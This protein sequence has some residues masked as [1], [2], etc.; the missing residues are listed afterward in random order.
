MIRKNMRKWWKCIQKGQWLGFNLLLPVLVGVVSLFKEVL[1]ELVVELVL[2][3]VEGLP[4]SG[5]VST[6]SSAENSHA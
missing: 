1:L 6:F 4:Q 2:V 5:T 3:C